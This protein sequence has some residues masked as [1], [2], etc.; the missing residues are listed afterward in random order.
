MVVKFIL[1]FGIHVVQ[2]LYQLNYSY[3]EF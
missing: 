2:Y 3:M 1:N